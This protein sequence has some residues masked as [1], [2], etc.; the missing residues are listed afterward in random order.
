MQ[1]SI[2]GLRIRSGDILKG[3]KRLAERESV[4]SASRIDEDAALPSVDTV[5][6]RFESLVS[7]YKIAGLVR[8]DG[9]RFDPT[10][11]KF[12]RARDDHS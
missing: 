11:S 3:P 7:A 10:T 6:R 12:V 1:G 9:E 8:L 4:I 5:F 2:P